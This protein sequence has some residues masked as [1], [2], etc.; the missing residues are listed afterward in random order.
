MAEEQETE[1]GVLFFVGLINAEER[2]AV[3]RL[4]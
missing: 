1:E 3:I 4:G 2:L